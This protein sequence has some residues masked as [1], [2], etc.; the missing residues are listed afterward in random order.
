M[1]VTKDGIVESG[2]MK[3]LR[4]DNG[5]YKELHNAQFSTI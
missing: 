3:L 4:K 1:V 2:A 5:V